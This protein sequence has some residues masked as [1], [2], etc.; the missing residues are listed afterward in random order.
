MKNDFAIERARFLYC[1]QYHLRSKG[2]M[3]AWTPV[4]NYALI[5]FQTLSTCFPRESSNNTC[6]A[7]RAQSPRQ[8]LNN[9]FCLA[10][11]FIAIFI[12]SPFFFFDK[13]FLQ[14]NQTRYYWYIET[15]IEIYSEYQIQLDLKDN[16]SKNF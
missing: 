3:H 10:S 15:V 13:K 8:N 14:F 9:W 1:F 11:F 4:C 2:A 7:E 5:L 16:D 6:F 12:F